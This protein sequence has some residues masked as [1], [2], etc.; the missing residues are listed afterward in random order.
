M[1]TLD[2]IIPIFNPPSGWADNLRAGLKDFE[3][4]LGDV[5]LNVI[6]VNDGSTSGI[7]EN[8]IESLSSDFELFQFVEYK[9][10]KGK[11]N[12]VREGMKSSNSDFSMF[13]DVD[14]P[15]TLESMIA[16]AD[17][18]LQGD[19]DLAVGIRDEAYYSNLPRFRVRLSKALRSA[20]GFFFSLPVNDTQAGLKGFSKKGKEVLMQT[21]I[22]RY[23]FDLEMI[24]LAGRIDVKVKSVPIS[25]RGK[26]DASN[27]KPGILLTEFFNFLKIVGR[28]V[29]G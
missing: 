9:A 20:V 26:I 24:F 19:C 16:V 2:L 3:A 22:S 6:L 18:I 12:A 1:T 14:L 13:T 15:Y 7:S 25:L 10:N 17:V 23:L 5:K 11:G 29:L 28:R 8:E 27:M 4:A 21:T